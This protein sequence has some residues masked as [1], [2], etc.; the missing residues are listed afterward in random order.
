MDGSVF[1]IKSYHMKLF[2]RIIFMMT[3]VAQT[4]YIQAQNPNWIAPDAVLFDFTASAITT[5]Y[6]DDI[7]SDNELD[8]VSFFVNGE[9]RGLSVPIDI[10]N[11]EYRHFITLYSNEATEM[12]DIKVYH[13]D[14]DEVYDVATPLS[15][16]VQNIYGSVD[17]PLELDVYPEN[18]A[19]IY[20]T[21][22]AA[23][24]TIEGLAFDPIDME[25][26]LVQVDPN[27]VEWTYTANPDLVVSFSGSI[28]SVE[29][30]AGFN[31][32]TSLVV[33]ATE[34]SMTAN[35]SNLGAKS[36]P[37]A[38]YAE[39]IIEYT[40]TP[41]YAAPAWSAIPGQGIV[42]GGAFSAISLDSFEYQYGG[43]S[44]IYDYEPIIMESGVPVSN[45]DWVMEVNFSTN[46]TITAQVNYT[47]KYQ[48]D[49]E[50][51]ALV[52]FIDDEVRG[53]ALKNVNSGLYYLTVSGAADEDGMVSVGFYSGEMKKIFTLVNVSQFEPHKIEG[54]VENPVI[55]EMAPMIPVVSPNPIQ[56]GEYSMPIDIIDVDYV[57]TEYFKIFAYDPLYPDYLNAD[58]SASFCVVA[59][60]SMLTFWYADTDG[61]GFGDPNV[62]FASCDSIAGYVSNLFDCQDT[63]M[64]EAL[65]IFV[66][67]ESSGS[68]PNDSI[69][70]SGDNAVIDVTE[71]AEYSWSN[72]GTGQFIS[73]DPDSTSTYSVTV[74]FDSGCKDFG[75][76]DLFVEEKVVKNEANIG[77]NSLRSVFECIVEG[78]TIT[79]NQPIVSSSFINEPL[80]IDK[81]VYIYG[82]DDDN[83]PKISFDF[84]QTIT[85]LQ[86]QNS[87][88]L[89][90]NNIDL[91]FINL[92]SNTS[93]TG[94]GDL[95][96]TGVTKV[97]GQ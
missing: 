31:G 71:G 64:E 30:A 20:L 13:A 50:D 87:K 63:G 37:V 96:V 73:V 53:I 69:V 11:S 52:A 39:T 6:L 4:V 60:S 76:I 10:G 44:I 89:I 56:G 83:R 49:H 93:L 28:M 46:M 24:T 95:K 84:N 41:L 40:V 85:G 97:S 3:L 94:S 22:I 48:F 27:Q 19:P 59:D 15:F 81:N 21:P 86:I 47:P 17:I 42:V 2:I 62:F 32:T 33:R 90:L 55:L 26:Y 80:I 23:K 75:S 43:D 67:S 92:G 72:G 82:L 70:C 61:D 25:D 14:T 18:D 7:R 9:I 1:F 34:I 66:V 29:D 36:L 57:G 5:V 78:D 16:G 77:F 8:R 38:Q 58:T 12:M 88:S 54:S 35:Q 51:D 68:T 91:E 79:Y 45:P 74:T 65:I